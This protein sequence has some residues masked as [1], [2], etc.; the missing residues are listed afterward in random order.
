MSLSIFPGQLEFPPQ[1]IA[2]SGTRLPFNQASAPFGW[3]ADTN[4]ALADCS[5][6]VNQATGG[7]TGG[8]TAWSTWNGGGTVAVNG[9]NLT[10]ANI[11]SHSHTITDPGH[12]HSAT[13]SGHLHGYSNGNVWSTG[14]SPTATFGSTGT[15]MGQSSSTNTGVANVSIGSATTGINTT[16]AFGSGTMV[17]PTLTTP[18]VKF[19]DFFI[20]IK[21]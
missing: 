7:A 1:L 17:N 10:S 4:A 18:S 20:G 21:S 11:P 13:D 12:A 5:F 14:G 9:F 3:A 15:T 19:T 2:P 8:G 16:N 6:R